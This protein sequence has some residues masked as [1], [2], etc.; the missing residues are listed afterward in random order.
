[1]EPE[2][3]LGKY[4]DSLYGITLRISSSLDLDNVLSYLTEETAGALSVKASSV[5]LLDKDG[6]RLEMRAVYGLSESYLNKGPVEVARSPVDQEIL[7]GNATQ[8]QDVTHDPSFQYPDEAAR[9]GIVSVASVPLIA[10]GRAI[11]VLRVYSSVPRVFS[12]ADMKFLTAVADLA[13][14]AIENARLYT[15]IRT[16]Y[17]DTMNTLWGE[18]PG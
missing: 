13:A 6:K 8:L 18:P 12:D 7:S 17:E 14:L 2:G 11:G 5:R 10:H 15:E 16:S 3:S 4:F 9:E 1:M